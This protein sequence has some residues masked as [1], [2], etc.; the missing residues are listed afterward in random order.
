M[1]NGDPET[2]IEIPPDTAPPDIPPGGPLEA[3]EPLPE[4]P[5]E[6][7]TEVPPPPKERG[8]SELLEEMSPFIP[9][10]GARDPVRE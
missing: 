9:P 8:H 7:P 2:P 4:L 3:P 10:A 5:P 1:S 6:T